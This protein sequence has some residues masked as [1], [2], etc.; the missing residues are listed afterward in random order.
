MRN[1]LTKTMDM[2]TEI[3]QK[4]V[5]LRK[6]MF[7]VWPG[8]MRIALGIRRARRGSAVLF[9]PQSGARPAPFFIYSNTMQRCYAIY[10]MQSMLCNLCYVISAKQSMLYNKCYTVLCNGVQY[11]LLRLCSAIY[12]MQS[13]LCNICYAI[14]AM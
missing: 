3:Y 8:G 10:A 5:F 11:M 12:A 2:T 1:D 9:S 14:Y 6:Y 13:M 7:G 4:G